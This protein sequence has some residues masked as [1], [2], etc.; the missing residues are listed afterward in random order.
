[1]QP[2]QALNPVQQK[3]KTYLELL[4]P[5]VRRHTLAELTAFVDEAKRYSGEE[6]LR[7]LYSMK[8][9]FEDLGLKKEAASTRSSLIEFATKE[10]AQRYIDLVAT[11]DIASNDYGDVDNIKNNL[12]H[13]YNKSSDSIVKVHAKHVLAMALFSLDSPPD[14]MKLLSEARAMIPLHDNLRLQMI[15]E[16]EYL[17]ASAYLYYNDIDEALN[18]SIDMQSKNPVAHM[19]SMEDIVSREGVLSAATISRISVVSVNL[20]DEVAARMAQRAYLRLFPLT[21]N[22]ALDLS[23]HLDCAK[24]EDA[25]GSQEAVLRCLNGSPSEFDKNPE[26]KVKSEILRGIAFARLGRVQEAKSELA[27]LEKQSILKTIPRFH[28]DTERLKAWIIG[29]GTKNQ[30]SLVLLDSSWRRL[31]ELRS[32]AY[33]ASSRQLTQ[34]LR[35]N[36]RTLKHSDEQKKRIIELETVLTSAALIGIAAILTALFSLRRL[37]RELVAARAAAEN[38]NAVK[39]E[40]LANISHEIRTPMNGMMGMI[41]ALELGDINAEQKTQL[42]VMRRSSQGV[43]GLL[44]DL[45]DLSKIEAGKLTL[46][47]VPFDA[48]QAAEELVAVFAPAAEEKGVEVRLTVEPEA[49]GRFLGDVLRWRQVLANLLS[50]AVKFTERGAVT[51]ALAMDGEALTFTVTDSGLGMTPE[52]LSRLF[53]KFEQADASTTRKFGG[54]G[55]GLAITRQLILAMGGDV[56]VESVYGEGSTF[57]VSI[58]MPRVEGAGEDEDNAADLL[59]EEDDDDFAPLRILVAEDHPVNQLV[60]ST[61]I[62]RLGGDLTVVGDGE[63]AVSAFAMGPWDLV[64]LDIQMP[65]L[66]GYEAV[67]EIRKYEIAQGL[68]R[69]PIVA[70]TAN[71]MTHQVAGY[72]DAGFDDQLGKPI[73]LRALAELMDRVRVGH[74][75]GNVSDDRAADLAVRG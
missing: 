8:V 11:D 62:G 75:A 73:E 41:Q 15:N 51:V 63:E 64:M 37:N 4:A 48:A 26:A 6:R 5:R 23:S 25:F 59:A 47:E 9:V 17:A 58:P 31:L 38:A 18:Y 16:N 71:M 1:M 24:L 65:I 10:H 20:G 70:L 42:Q 46:E 13:I 50:N 33:V 67:A 69:T 74:Y 44:N 61:L 14:T 7:R 72:R 27:W 39:D 29:A 57:R 2:V 35:D 49:E 53:Q 54:T 60:I 56:T 19:N 28:Y 34:E 32:Q 3:L 66:D 55:L 43:L 45:L 22:S 36:V 68:S 30:Q 21:Q 12:N 40:F 52:Q